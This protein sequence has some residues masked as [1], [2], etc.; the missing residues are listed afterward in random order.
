[1]GIAGLWHGAGF[2]FILWG[3]AHGAWLWL[4]RKVTFTLPRAVKIFLVF[5]GVCLLW[6]LFRAPDLNIAGSYFARLFLPPW[7]GAAV[8]GL[9]AAWLVGFALLMSPL[10]ALIEGRRFLVLRVR[11]QVAASAALLVFALAHAG[12]RIDFIYFTF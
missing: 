1:M 8:P 9:L 2:T 6:V 7:N 12:A 11:W 3:L 10:A 4:E 5:H